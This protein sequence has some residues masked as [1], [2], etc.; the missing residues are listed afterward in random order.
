MKISNRTHPVLEILEKDFGYRIA[1]FKGAEAEQENIRRSFHE[2]WPVYRKMF[3]SNINYISDS[4]M[5]AADFALPKI[6]QNI[7]KFPLEEKEYKG[8]FF[9]GKISIC[10]R[11]DLLYE[12]DNTASFK[13]CCFFVFRNE[14][15]ISI[16]WKKDNEGYG[17]HYET[18]DHKYF[19][20]TNAIEKITKNWIWITWMWLVFKKYAHVE[21]KFLQAGKKTKDI[22]CKYV[23]DSKSNITMLD[24]KWFTTLVKSDGFKVRGHFH[25]YWYKDESGAKYQKLQWVNTYDKEGYTAPAKKITQ[26]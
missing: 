25:L 22:T 23:N 14:G 12:K 18:E 20:G 21:T 17:F 13:K 15:A 8:V 9:I 5:Q 11:F 1:C 16:M 10:Y 24:S 3:A 19:T 6:R 7:D 4:F 2:I 26:E